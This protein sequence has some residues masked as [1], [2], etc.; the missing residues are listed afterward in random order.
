MR[1]VR[2]WL[3]GIFVTLVVGV[4]AYAGPPPTATGI[5]LDPTIHYEF[6]NASAT[7]S[8]VQIIPNGKYLLQVSGDEAVNV[9]YGTTYDGGT[10]KR[11]RGK[12]LAYLESFYAADGG[13]ALAVQ[14]A[15]ATGDLYLD[16]TH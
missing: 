4:I 7:G 15:G 1:N 12:N 3:A 9:V 6:T 10:L 2:K 16:G 14:S 5:W 8:A 13:T 11:Y